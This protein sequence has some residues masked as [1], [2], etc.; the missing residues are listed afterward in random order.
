[1]LFNIYP[2]IV[3]MRKFG[4]PKAYLV[5]SNILGFVLLAINIGLL[6]M[7]AILCDRN[8]YTSYGWQFGIILITLVAY[9]LMGALVDMAI[10]QP[11]RRK[12]KIKMQAAGAA[13]QGNNTQGTRP[14]NENPFEGNTPN[15]TKPDIKDIFE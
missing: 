7:F 11:L 6:A 13:T 4:I 12:Y 8:G 2:N 14:N 15:N 9:V 3:K 5:W 10:M 1:M